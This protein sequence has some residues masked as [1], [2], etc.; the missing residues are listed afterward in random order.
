MRGQAKVEGYVA[1]PQMPDA[2][3]AVFALCL[4]AARKIPVAER[5]AKTNH[6]Y[7]GLPMLLLMML[8]L[9]P[10]STF[11]EQPDKIAEF[12]RDGMRKDIAL[13]TH[14]CLRY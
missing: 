12:N 10:G 2:P 13:P 11:I 7:H 6:D 14:W 8:S 9:M 4:V 3:E 5:P 1:E